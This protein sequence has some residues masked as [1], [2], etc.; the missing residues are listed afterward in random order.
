MELKQ[1]VSA[2]TLL[3]LNTLRGNIVKRPL[4]FGL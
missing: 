3:V 4:F 1:G 2:S